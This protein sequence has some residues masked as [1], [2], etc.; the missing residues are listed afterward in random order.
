ME[1]FRRADAVDAEVHLDRAAAN[2]L[3]HYGLDL[4]LQ[5]AVSL[6][7]ADGQLE[8]AVVDG[9]DLDRDGQA[10]ALAMRFAKPGHA[11]EHGKNTPTLGIL[12]LQSRSCRRWAPLLACPAVSNHVHRVQHCWTGQQWHPVFLRY[13]PDGLVGRGGLAVWAGGGAGCRPLY[14]WPVFSGPSLPAS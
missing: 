3:P 2:A 7:G 4:R 12:K 5:R 13:F 14:P 11:Q 9:A 6:G 10:V 8:V 1:L